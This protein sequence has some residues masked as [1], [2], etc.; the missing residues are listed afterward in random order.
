V[1]TSGEG[2]L[3]AGLLALLVPAL[4]G[5]VDPTHIYPAWVDLSMETGSGG[6]TPNVPYVIISL[7]KSKTKPLPG[8]NAGDFSGR[9]VVGTTPDG[10]GN[11]TSMVEAAR[12]VQPVR[13]IIQCNGLIGPRVVDQVSNAIIG[14]LGQA[15]DVPLPDSMEAI[16]SINPWTVQVT[17]T[18]YGLTARLTLNSKG[19]VNNDAVRHE[20][21]YDVVYEAEYSTYKSQVDPFITGVDLTGLVLF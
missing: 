12:E 8:G 3:R 20:Y 16:P 21:R 6:L 19:S 14:A 9:S 13:F 15:S 17:G 1:S 4:N 10:S 2:Q 7:E 11:V 5:L 18:V